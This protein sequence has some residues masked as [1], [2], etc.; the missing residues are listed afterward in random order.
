MQ[1]IEELRLINN[2]YKKMKEQYA[3]IK[4]E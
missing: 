3:K 4:K 2:V 1:L